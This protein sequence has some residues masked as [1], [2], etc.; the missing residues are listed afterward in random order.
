MRGKVA[1]QFPAPGDQRLSFHWLSPAETM[2]LEAIQQCT[3]LQ[4]NEESNQ[5]ASRKEQE[6]AYLSNWAKLI[7]LDLLAFPGI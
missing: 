6:P 3:Q 2:G 1:G 4:P 7:H 5:L